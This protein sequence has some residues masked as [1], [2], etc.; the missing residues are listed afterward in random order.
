MR[1]L[2][3]GVAHDQE[4]DVGGVGAAQDVVRGRFDHFAVGDDDLAPVEGFLFMA[5]AA[6]SA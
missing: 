3:E 1:G 6:M 4:R 2:P 5:R